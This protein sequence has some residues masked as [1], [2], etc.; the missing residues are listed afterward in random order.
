MT[1][2]QQHRLGISANVQ[3]VLNLSDFHELIEK[4]N[5]FCLIWFLIGRRWRIN[6]YYIS[7]TSFWMYIFLR[8]FWSIKITSYKC[9]TVNYTN[10]LFWLY[11]NRIWTSF[12][13]MNQNAFMYF[14][15][16]RKKIVSLII[17]DFIEKKV[18]QAC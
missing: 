13:I 6:H 3:C 11:W 14:Y 5:V 10:L 17:N 18:K 2:I 4:M 7:F 8:R 1:R 15:A 9:Q 12:Y 16:S